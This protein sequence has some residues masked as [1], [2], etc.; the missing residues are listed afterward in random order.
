MYIDKRELLSPE[1]RTLDRKGEKATPLATLG[2]QLLDQKETA[3]HGEG[4]KV[5]N[6]TKLFN[7]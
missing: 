2:L 3:E 1:R 7:F 6:M 4:E 5:D